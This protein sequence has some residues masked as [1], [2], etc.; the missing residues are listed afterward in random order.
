[1][2]F[3]K[4]VP[5]PVKFAPVVVNVAAPDVRPAGVVVAVVALAD[6]N[7][8]LVTASSVNTPLVTVTATVVAAPW[9]AEPSAVMSVVKSVPSAWVAVILTVANVKVRP[10]PPPVVKLVNAVGVDA[11]L[12]TPVA[13]A[14]TVVVTGAIDVTT[15]P[16]VMFSMTM[17]ELLLSVT[18]PLNAIVPPAVER[19]EA[20]VKITPLNCSPPAKAPMAAVLPKVAETPALPLSRQLESKILS[21]KGVTEPQAP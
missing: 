14:V 4:T 11:A 10:A 6:T 20:L 9:P 5:V 15:A 2:K 17:L 8:A 3:T 1:M 12:V 19:P 7:C 21:T 16:E 18:I 13:P